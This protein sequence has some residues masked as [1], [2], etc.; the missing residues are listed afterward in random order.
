MRPDGFEDAVGGARADDVEHGRAAQEVVDAEDPVLRYEPPQ[1]GV[2]LTRTRLVGAERLLEHEHRALGQIL[3]FERGARRGA[4]G[5][6]QGE[7]QHERGAGCLGRDRAHAVRGRGV[8]REEAPEAHA[9]ERL[10][11]LRRAE[12]LVDAFAPGL[13]RH[14][15]AAGAD[16]VYA[17]IALLGEQLRERGQQQALREV[18]RCAEDGQRRL[19]G[20]DTTLLSPFSG[21]TGTMSPMAA[22]IEDYALLSDCR[23][24]ALVSRDGSTDWL[25]LPRLDSPSIFGAP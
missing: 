23:T 21:G 4:D 9:I 2:E 22:P 20:H 19:L 8:D 15:R 1:H 10:L 13:L 6:R 5:R 11:R 14:S 3:G 16:E 12:R 7:V 25:C 17:A 24:A 18:A